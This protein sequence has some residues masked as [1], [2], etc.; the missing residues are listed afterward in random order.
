MQAR[1]QSECK[2]LRVNFNQFYTKLT[3]RFLEGIQA[4]KVDAL[5]DE[6]MGLTSDW[7]V[8]MA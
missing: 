5:G 1:F 4:D 7:V 8:I 3:R 6:L 2:T